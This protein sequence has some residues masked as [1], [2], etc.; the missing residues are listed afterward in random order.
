MYIFLVPQYKND[1]KPLENIQRRT[2]KMV[3]GLG[4]KMYGKQLRLLGV[5]SPE[6]RR[7]RGGFMVA[8]APHKGSR[9]AALSSA[10]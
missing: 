2:T 3:K 6:Q 8:T 9:G 10:L 4:G 7:L 5:F 1:I